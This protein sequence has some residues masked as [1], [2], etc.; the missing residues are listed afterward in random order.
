M[1]CLETHLLRSF[2]EQVEENGVLKQELQKIWEIE[3][4]GSATSDVVSKFEED[5]IHN[6]T[7][8][9]VKLPFKPDHDL[10]PDNC[11]VCEQRL[12]AFKTRLLSKSI[13]SHYDT[14]FKDYEKEGIIERV[15]VEEIEKEAGTTHYL[16]HRPVIREDKQTTKIRAVFDA[17]CKINGPSLNECLYAGPNL[18][19][20]I[21]HVL[22]RFRFNKIGLLADIK[23]AFLNVEI[24]SEHRDYLRF[25]WYVSNAE[26]SRAVVYRF[27]RV[28]FGV[29]S[30]P[31][32]LNGTVKHHLDQY[33]ENR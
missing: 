31:F 2:L 3:S 14:I 26:K 22:V 27:L 25:L 24:A 12:K 32:L 13:Y 30:S 16:P 29:T 28:V 17:S 23:Q 5:I 11:N 7:R 19:S 4:V 20:K 15:R 21:F 33:A 6:G 18:I 8:F 9:V 1:D 10:L